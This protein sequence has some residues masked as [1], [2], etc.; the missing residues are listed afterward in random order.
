MIDNPPFKDK[1]AFVSRAMSFKKPFAF[2]LPLRALELKTIPALFY[3][4]NIPIEILL[5]IEKMEFE[6]QPG[7]KNGIVFKV[8]YMCSRI[9]EKQIVI[10]DMKKENIN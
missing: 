6:N 9:L 10:A 2:L 4:F 3:S 5:P 8:I 1:T 7:R